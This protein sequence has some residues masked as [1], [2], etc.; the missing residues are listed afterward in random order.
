MLLDSAKYF[1]LNSLKYR[2]MKKV[3]MTEQANRRGTCAKLNL[4]WTIYTARLVE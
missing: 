1:I 2:N 3:I 4:Q